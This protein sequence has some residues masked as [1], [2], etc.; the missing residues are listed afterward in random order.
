MRAL[1]ALAVNI[2]AEVIG[3]ANIKVVPKSTTDSPRQGTA[4]TVAMMVG[5]QLSE[6]TD[7]QMLPKTP[8]PSRHK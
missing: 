2:A 6:A 8:S 3:G 4:T 5:F 7:C 1:L